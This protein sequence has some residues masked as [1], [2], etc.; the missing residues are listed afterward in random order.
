MSKT[1]ILI[2]LSLLYTI[3]RPLYAI[4]G[5]PFDRASS[6]EVLFN[7]NSKNFYT[8]P[9]R[10][11]DKR[12]DDFEAAIINEIAK[13]QKTIELA[14]QEL[15]LPG[16]VDALVAKAEEG[17]KVRVV[18]ENRYNKDVTEI[19]L[20]VMAKSE[21]EE[22]EQDMTR[23]YDLFAFIDVNGD[24]ELSK[25]E[26]ENRD[27]IYKLR[28]A[29]IKIKDDTA[30]LSHGSGLMHHKFV[31]IDNKRVVLSSAN[32][33]LS[34][35]HGDYTSQKSTGNANAMIIITSNKVA[36]LFLEE[37]N[38]MW[39][40]AN[41][42]GKSLFGI[43]KPYRGPQE[44]VVG[45]TKIKV[46][47]S[48]TSKTKA[49]EESVNGMIGQA[50]ATARSSVKMGLFVYADQ[51]LSEVLRKRKIKLPRLRIAA[52]VEPRFAYRYYSEL[53]DLWGVKL[54]DE[55]CEYESG[56]HPWRRDRDVVGGVP[57]LPTGDVL[58]HKFGVIDTQRVIFGSQNWSDTANHINDEY[59]VVIENKEVAQKF[60]DEFD[61]IS[62]S[63]RFGPPRSLLER[64]RERE[65]TCSKR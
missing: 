31:V 63:A 13:A 4:D 22:E 23:Y 47:F 18:L 48:P 56:N 42:R 24:G 53:L 35:V 25:S 49:W 30:D 50:L 34:G 36:L 43:N 55:N 32:F 40:G 6:V 59:A 21:D 46:Q 12:G 26:L 39:G 7:N 2:I 61:R 41:G 3:G 33:T 8:D 27:A 16:I 54:L 38:F 44:V 37:F 14:V 19:G 29:K 10:G 17:I 5:M 9:Y 20:G 1:N 45:S 51:N 52:L 62:V 28:K 64:I 15:R 65:D 57:T 11:I 60:E 58:H